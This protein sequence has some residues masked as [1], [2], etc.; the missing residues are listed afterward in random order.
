MLT[1]H[2]LKFD[3]KTREHPGLVHRIEI[4]H[5]EMTACGMYVSSIE[6]VVSEM[7]KTQLMLEVTMEGIGG[8][9]KSLCLIHTY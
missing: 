2:I 5:T 1:W 9:V 4:R 6:Q 3:G 7:P 8:Y